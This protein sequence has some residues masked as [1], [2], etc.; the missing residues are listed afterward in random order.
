MGDAL[1]GCRRSESIGNLVAALV[2]VQ[3][4]VK[5]PERKSENPFFKSHYADLKAVSDACRGLL[6]QNG[7]A[8]MQYA[9]VIPGQGA[10]LVTTLAHVSGEWQ[11]GALPLSPTKDDPQSQGSALTYARRYSLAAMIGLAPAD[12]DDDDEGAMP[13]R[14]TANRPQYKPPVRVVQK[15]TVP[16]PAPVTVEP[17]RI[18]E[19][20]AAIEGQLPTAMEPPA[21]T[22]DPLAGKSWGPQPV[23]P[24]RDAPKE[25]L[26]STLKC[27]CG[28]AITKGA[29]MYCEKNGITP[30]VCPMCIGKGSK[31]KKQ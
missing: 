12:D 5:D 26:F 20:A 18:R 14:P 6:S 17:E 11:E 7:L 13:S 27:A 2:K 4:A 28:R 1:I 3:A 10:A 22:A 31:G 16:P 25:T 15:V 29:V 9:G 30:P 19:A 21:P 23:S 8:V 24:P